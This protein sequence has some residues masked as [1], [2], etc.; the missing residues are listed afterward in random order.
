MRPV[1]VLQFGGG[2]FLR[3][4]FNWMMQKAID[5]GVYDGN[6]VIVRSRTTGADP[7]AENGFKYT[8][9]AR[10]G[11]H[12]D[13][14]DIDCISGSV[15]IGSDDFYK[16]ATSDDLEVVVSNTTEAGIVYKEEGGTYPYFL[17]EFLRK[18]YLAGK[19]GLLIIPCEL[20]ENNGDTLKEYVLAHAKDSGFCEWLERECD[21]R[22]TLVDRIVSGGD[23]LT[24]SSE[25]F[26]LFVIS[27][28]ED[29][30]LPFAKA[31][32]NVKWVDDVNDY[33]KI[34]VRVLNGAHTSMIPHALLCGCETVADCLENGEIRTH[35]ENCLSEILVTLDGAEDYARE[36]L[37]RFANPHIDHKCRAI[38][39][40]SFEKFKVRVLPSILEY[41]KITGENPKTLLFSLYELVRFYKEDEP[42]DDA[43]V[44]EYIRSGS[45]E[46]IAADMGIEL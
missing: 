20:I 27:G 46:K 39:L 38:A 26:H 12:N 2:V 29:S 5:A 33:R 17:T 28:K 22:N 43:D 45:F 18:R 42:S 24:N 37:S 30:R 11:A 40:N 44:I 19:R 1:R 9:I 15:G 3:G 7:L 23:A 13:L 6:A 25:Y 35:L 41:K 32:L 16:Y 21:F 8:H 14:T 31:G 4:F 36:V 34:K 10:D